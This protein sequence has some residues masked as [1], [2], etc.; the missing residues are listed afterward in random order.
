MFRSKTTGPAVL[1]T[2]AAALLLLVPVATRAA[3][4]LLRLRAFAVDRNVS[5]AATATIT[6][7]IERW[8]T[9]A[10]VARLKD[11]LVE[12]GPD[13]LHE[14]L[15]ELK[16][17]AGHIS[18]TGSLGWDIHFARQEPS[19][20]SRRIVIA[21]DRP[22]GFWELWRRPRSADYNFTLAEIRLRP[23]GKGEGKLATAA[24]VEWNEGLKTIEIENYTIEPVRLSE[25]TVEK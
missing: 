5:P 16:P 17:R 23:D 12:K 4:P 21:T 22:M 1:L 25:V 11:A 15:R 7:V 19:G 20:D 14:A 13:A 24:K 3:D 10:E 18:T 8:S 2:A 9:D 6:I